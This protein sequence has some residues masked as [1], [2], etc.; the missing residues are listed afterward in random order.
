M[1]RK[2][3]GLMDDGVGS[4]NVCVTF[5]SV[6]DCTCVCED[7]CVGS[8]WEARPTEKTAGD[9]GRKRSNLM[10]SVG[11]REGGKDEVRTGVGEEER[12]EREK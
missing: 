6:T 5:V 12:E 3:M 10:R 7:G 11:R 1:N 9:S 8:E 4:A 2:M